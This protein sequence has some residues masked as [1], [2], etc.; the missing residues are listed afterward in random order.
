MLYIPQQRLPERS[1][2]VCFPHYGEKAASGV[3]GFI[4]TDVVGETLPLFSL[5][6]RLLRCTSGL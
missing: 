2:S 5:H 4:G 3:L 6:Y 1:P